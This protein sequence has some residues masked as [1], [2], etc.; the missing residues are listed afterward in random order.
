MTRVSTFLLAL[1]M[2][3]PAI[4]SAEVP[5]LTG[6]GGTR[7][8]G[9][10]CLGPN[11]DG[12]SHSVDLTPVFPSGIHFFDR[13][14]TSM[15]V[16][17]NGN[18]T[19]SGE[20]PQYTPDAFPVAD[21]PM[22]APFWA[23]VDIR[24]DPTDCEEND[25]GGGYAGDCHSPSANGVWW[26]VDAAGRRVVVTW[27]QVGYF[28]CR[29]DKRMSF[30]L[31]LTPVPASACAMEGD[32]DVE[33]R[34]QQCEWNTGDASGGEGGLAPGVMDGRRRQMCTTLPFLGETCP[35]DPTAACTGGFCEVPATPAQ[36]GFD[37]GNST[38][39]VEIP[40]SRTNEIH[41]ILCSMSNVGEPG[42]WRFQIRR[43]SVLCPDAGNACDTGGV[44]VCGIGRTAC[45]RGETECRQDLMASDER[46]DALDNDCDGT[47]DE[48]GG[49]CGATE[50]CSRG[51][52]IAPCFEGGCSPGLACSPDGICVDEA[53]VGVTCPAGQRCRLGACVGA[54]DGVVCPGDRTCVSGQCVDTCAGTTCDDCTVCQGGACVARC[55]PGSCPTGRECADDGRCVD[56]GC[57]A[58]TCGAG[59]V[60][61]GGACVDACSGAVCPTGESCSVGDC[62]PTGM[63]PPPPSDGGT[64]PDMDGSVPP[65]T[66]GG[67]SSPPGATPGCA[68]RAQTATPSSYGALL[69]V[70]GLALLRRRRSAR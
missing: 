22:I 69:L 47:V 28:D 37:A 25:G 7:D 31:V 3:V 6:F 40:G 42:V 57:A 62:Y 67:G 19:F 21:Q 70:A 61:R 46:C 54:C 9:S 64:T 32:F 33:F 60:C 41:S 36:S 5:L 65:G 26:A 38:D 59:E 20:L 55:A 29:R 52:C 44:G 48:G 66:D 23:D 56:T 45:V 27:D 11:D 13:T 17:T 16:N 24:F 1:V 12:S 18:V 50:V 8:F 39:W 53:C 34:F 14:H 35:G 68:C 15:Y 30:Q 49:L 43:G 58:L 63:G 10:Q 4:A 51:V 2:M